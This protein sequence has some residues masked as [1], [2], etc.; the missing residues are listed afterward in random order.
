MCIAKSVQRA[1]SK[2]LRDKKCAIY[3]RRV[4]MARL[5]AVG[6]P[7]VRAHVLYVRLEHSN[8]VAGVSRALMASFRMRR[9]KPRVAA[10]RLAPR[11]HAKS[12]EARAVDFATYAAPV[13]FRTELHVRF[14]QQGGIKIRIMQIHAKSARRARTRAS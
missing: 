7:P 11:V 2:I 4:P 3:G 8:V 12:A 10:V 6:A 14:V 1:D 13:N 9:G 5:R